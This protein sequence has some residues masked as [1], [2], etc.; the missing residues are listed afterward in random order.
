[1]APMR[2]AGA[3][4]PWGPPLQW[5]VLTIHHLPSRQVCGLRRQRIGVTFIPC[6]FP[7]A[8]FWA[9]RNGSRKGKIHRTP[10]YLDG[11]KMFKKQQKKHIYIYIVRCS[12]QSIQSPFDLL[13][14]HF[15]LGLDHGHRCPLDFPV[16]CPFNHSFFTE[17]GL[18]IIAYCGRGVR[19]SPWGLL[20]WTC[21]LDRYGGFL[22]YGYPQSPVLIHFWLGFS[23]INH[24][25]GKFL[26]GVPS[27]G[28]F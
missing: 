28:D 13:L 6:V 23:I 12:I 9:T 14:P 5:H 8:G 16:D 24:L 22:K 3:V 18:C 25:S 15:S 21:F 7:A 2:P 20:G 26:W 27:M 1:M 4:W 10:R 11:N 19:P 17:S